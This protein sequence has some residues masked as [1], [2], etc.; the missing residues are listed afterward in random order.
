MTTFQTN[1]RGRGFRIWLSE[2]SPTKFRTV[3]EKVRVFTAVRTFS[4]TDW[5]T[6]SFTETPETVPYSLKPLLK[7]LENQSFN[8]KVLLAFSFLCCKPRT[9]KLPIYD[10][11]IE[12]CWKQ[13]FTDIYIYSLKNIEATQFNKSLIITK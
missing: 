6:L 1:T 11:W 7:Y 10:S 4:L 2:F 3:C 5:Q 13:I 9:G 8:S 12:L